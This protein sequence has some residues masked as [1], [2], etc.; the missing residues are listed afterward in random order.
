MRESEHFDFLT[1]QVLPYLE[2][3]RPSKVLR[4]WSAGC[5]AGQEAYTVAMAI[6]EYFGTRKAGWDTSILATDISM[7]VL[8]RAKAAVYPAADIKDISPQWRSK[9][10]VQKGADQFQVCDKIRKE[11]IFRPFNLMDPIPFKNPFDLI[12]CRNVMIY[13]DM[14]TKEKLVERFYNHTV[15]GGYLFIGHSE[16][17]NRSATRFQ[18]IKPA[19]YRK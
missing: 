12:L 18:Y 10:F 17:I 1:K 15:S 5:S 13:F 9:Y 6:D 11:V 19:I 8:S 14:E 2:A 7:N 16:G 3:N 4:I